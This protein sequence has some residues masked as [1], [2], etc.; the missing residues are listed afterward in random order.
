V[1]RDLDLLGKPAA[2]G[3]ATVD[4]RSAPSTRGRND[5]S[6]K[7]TETEMSSDATPHTATAWPVPGEPTLWSVTWLPGRALTRDQAM[8]AMTIA[9]TVAGHADTQNG[10][11]GWQLQLGSWAAELGLS[12]DEAAEMASAS[13]ACGGDEGRGAAEAVP[14]RANEIGS[15]CPGWCSA[16]HVTRDRTIYAHISDPVTGKLP[17]ETR[18]RLVQDGCDRYRP[19]R[20]VVDVSK[21]AAVVQLDAFQ[22]AGFASLLEELA[23]GCTPYQLRALADEVRAAASAIDPARQ[24]AATVAEM[25]ADRETK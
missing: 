14:V 25:S 3:I 6:T 7:I 2:G 17:W 19:G 15:P 13:L 18:V 21:I 10:A 11:E 12:A 5:M 8:T 4:R 16:G 24:L 23:D 1:T 9:E 20:P 22:A